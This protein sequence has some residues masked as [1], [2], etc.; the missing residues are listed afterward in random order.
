MAE[1]LT[2]TTTLTELV[3]AEVINAAIIEY[4]HDFVV[5]AQ[6]MNW[7][8][9]RGKASNVGSFPRWVLD[10]TTD[11]ANESTDMTSVALETTA[12]NIT[13]AEIGIF[14]R[15]TDAAIEMTTIGAGL[16]D[17]L[18]MDSAVLCAISL[19]DDI[20]ALFPS[21][22]TSV[23]TSG[24]DLTLANMVEAQAQIR[25]NGMRGQLAYILDDQQ[26]SDYQAA[27]AAATSTTINS[28]MLPNVTG[29][30][31]NAYLGTFF[32]A[33]VWQTGLC[34]T[35]NTAAN[36]VGACIIRGDTNPRQAPF[37]AVLSRDIT[38]EFDRDLPSRATHFGATAKWGVGEVADEGGCKIV[39]DA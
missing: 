9:L 21:L 3:N 32:N 38:T 20:V 15:I 26:A 4:A 30:S 29:S 2:T 18:T 22:T 34:D 5:S 28:L 27:Q 39:T 25:K 13:G 37:G 7:M 16:W 11:L 8:D 19:E 35:A 10:A 17:F 24:S 6:Y 36:V 1:T 12:V 23:G 31:D 14:R 33:P